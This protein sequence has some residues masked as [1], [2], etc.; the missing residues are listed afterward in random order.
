MSRVISL[1][2]IKT[3]HTIIWFI[4]ACASLY[5]LYAGITN[6]FGV[7]LWVSVG[8]LAFESITLLINRWTCP[9]TPIAMKFT[10]D[11]VDNFDIYLPLFIAKYNKIIFGTI[12]VIGLALVGINLFR[13]Y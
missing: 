9:L 10:E 7:W 3:L 4:M 12:Y 13:A 2:I 1:N 6:T 11:R 5:I 8:L